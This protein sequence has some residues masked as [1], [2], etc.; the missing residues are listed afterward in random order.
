MTSKPTA[1]VQTITPQ[2]AADLLARSKGNRNL[3]PQVVAQY[4]RDMAAGNWILTGEA[5]KLNGD[6]TLID[7]HHR[8]YACIQAETPFTTYVIENLTN[9][10]R[11]PM[12]SG[13]KRT[14]KD[15]LSWEGYKNTTQLA[16]VA[17]LAMLHQDNRIGGVGSKSGIKYS[18]R[19]TIQFIDG[20]LPR[21]VDACQFGVKLR[22][23]FDIG[24]TPIAFVHYLTGDG[25]ESYETFMN[26]VGVGAGLERETPEFTLRKWYERQIQEAVHG[27]PG[28]VTRAAVIIKTYNYWLDR[29][30]MSNV[31]WRPGAE[32]FPKVGS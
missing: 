31:Y 14:I 18:H 20:N 26:L 29:R 16:A 7:G 21:I 24:S 13:A 32:A 4:A 9:D 1:K 15:L 8:C 28:T 19:E 11:V 3:R 25:Y 30:P 5:I 10:I 2:K 23:T 12:D 17:R 27:T 6:G 22:N